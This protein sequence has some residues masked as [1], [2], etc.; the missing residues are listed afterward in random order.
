[1]RPFTYILA[2]AVLT[3]AL[4]APAQAFH[5]RSSV[6]VVAAGCPNVAVGLR[7]AN[8]GCHQAVGIPLAAS[9][10]ADPG[11]LVAVGAPSYAYQEPLAAVFV[12]QAQYGVG[13]RFEVFRAPRNVA[14]VRTPAA[15]VR[16]RTNAFGKTVAV[17]R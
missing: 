2:F 7:A 1:M 6:A 16:V 14:V 15:S 13:N 10:Y 9:Y 5:H 17:F 11:Q 12:P 3:F 8:L 4:A